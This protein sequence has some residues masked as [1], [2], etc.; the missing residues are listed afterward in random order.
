MS[1]RI[2]KEPDEI[3]LIKDYVQAEFQTIVEVMVRDNDIV[4]SVPSGALANTL[5]L[6]SPKIRKL[7]G[8]DKRLTFRIV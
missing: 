1:G 5:R 7:I 4:I 2:P 3:K 6:R 8:G